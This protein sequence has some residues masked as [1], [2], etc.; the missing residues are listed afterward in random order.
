MED[1]TY[2]NSHLVL[3]IKKLNIKISLN[4]IKKL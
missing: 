1:L 4:L 3:M 2:K